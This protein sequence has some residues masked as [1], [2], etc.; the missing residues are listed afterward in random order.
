MSVNAIDP[1]LR[2]PPQLQHISLPGITHLPQEVARTE[3]QIGN[4]DMQYPGAYAGLSPIVQIPIEITVSIFQ[5]AIRGG[6]NNSQIDFACT[7]SH[8]CHLWRSI[9]LSLP[10]LW[11]S[12]E[13]KHRRSDLHR[14][15]TYLQRSCNQLLDLRFEI[16]PTDNDHLWRDLLRKAVEHVSRWQRFALLFESRMKYP[17]NIFSI[18]KT[19]SAPN[20]EVIEVGMDPSSEG[21]FPLANS[22]PFCFK[23]GAPKL[24]QARFDSWSLKLSS[25]LTSITTLQI[26]HPRDHRETL[27]FASFLDLLKSSRLVNLSLS[28]PAYHEPLQG[29][30]PAVAPELRN[31]RIADCDAVAFNLWN[32]V[33]APK[34]ELLII[35]D[36]NPNTLNQ[37]LLPNTNSQQSDADQG[38]F[39][40]LSTLA[41][42]S[43]RIDSLSLSRIANLTKSVTSLYVNDC[44]C[45][46][47]F[48][49]D[50]N[51]LT[52]MTNLSPGTILWPQLRAVYC[53]MENFFQEFK[54]LEGILNA[55]TCRQD[56]LRT[57]CILNLL[58][59][60]A[61]AWE[62][63]DPDTW[64]ELLAGGFFMTWVPVAGMDLVP[65]PPQFL[66]KYSHRWDHIFMAC[67][68][69]KPNKLLST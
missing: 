46:G 26:A 58:D 22:A 37:T 59:S 44:D 24:L 34:L 43:C 40:S 49:E 66:Q 50:S 17:H 5:E 38:P 27:T 36:A 15:S 20:L 18:F 7:L 1:Q 32:Y 55:I 47:Y 48:S 13:Y 45:N 2:A 68:S 8:V 54:D 10:T 30:W 64:K 3:D 52:I 35:I 63:R 21:Q 28:G 9:S 56:F 16:G 29:T 19:L 31:F 61:K 42:V 51:P 4:I 6:E 39:P 65:W 67:Y 14:L 25:P 11:T 69:G 23:G 53:A 41:F 57:H 12:F 33:K 60:D 62:E